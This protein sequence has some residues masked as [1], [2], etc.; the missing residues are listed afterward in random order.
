MA[1]ALGRILGLVPGIL[2]VFI[3][4]GCSDTPVNPPIHGHDDL[5]RTAYGD[6]IWSPDGTILGFNH[7]PL[8]SITLGSMGEHVYHTQDSLAGFW[9]VDTT[10][11]NLHRVLS[12]FLGDPDWSPDGH[13]I[14]YETSGDIWRIATA[15]A[16]ID[17]LSG[18]RLTFLGS[19]FAPAWNGAGTKI[20]FYKPSGASA[21]LY[22]L[23]AGGGAPTQIG[24]QGWREPDYSWPDS[25]LA[26]VGSESGMYGIGTADSSGA[27]ATIVRSDLT[28][29]EEPHWS[30]DG[31]HIAFR[32]RE[33][34]T[35][36]V[37]L[38][39]MDGDG[40]N[41]RQLSP[42]AIGDGFAW[43]PDGTRI[44]YVRHSF[45]DFSLANGTIWIV[46]VGTGI[47]RQLTL[48]GSP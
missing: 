17:S 20:A 29:P 10:G 7:V 32:A 36:I 16:V 30:P 24:N 40:S 38:W 1:R 39:M 13:W 48:N 11:A 19:F 5:A 9:M 23:G 14:A 46:E 15:G 12:N 25:R 37:R 8:D 28:V 2:A 21:G 41:L 27:A 18:V 33:A 4:A 34:N 45:A 31:S 43:S 44:A 47:R 6:P 22:E 35:S 42:D 26:F 3:C